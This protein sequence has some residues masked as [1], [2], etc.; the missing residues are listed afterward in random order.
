MIRDE[1]SA[2]AMA[3]ATPADRD[4]W[5]DFLRALSILV[6]VV[7]HWLVAVVVWRDG[8]IEGFNALERIDGLW[9]ITWVLQVMPIFFFVGGFSN[10]VSLRAARRRGVGYAGYLHGR[11]TRM[12]RP[13][14][15]FLGL[16]VV[17][18][19]TLDALN[20]ADDIVFPV[21]TLITG[22]LW[23][24]GVYMIVVALAP[25]MVALHERLGFR[26][27]VAL[28]ALTG[29]VDLV[30][31][32]GGVSAVGYANYP[33][34]WL[35]AHQWGFVYADG[36]LTALR[37]RLLA[38]VGFAGLVAL[39]SFG[40]Y[41]LSMVG[42]A[43][44]EFS[45]MDPPTLCIVAL[46]M[47]E[48]GLAVATRGAV[49]RWLQRPRPWTAVI[50]VN[51]VIMTV[52]LWHLTVLVVAIGLLYPVGFPQPDV[53]T[54]SWWWWRPVWV[55]T[56]TVLLAGFVAA[57]G[58]VERRGLTRSPGGGAARPGSA[59]LAVVAVTA[60]LVGVL[61][62]AVGGLHQVFSPTGEDL[63]VMAVNPFQNV[64]HIAWGM[65]ALAA[66]SGR[67]GR[68]S[69]A[70]L[71]SMAMAAAL[72]VAGP[73]LRGLG[74]GNVLALDGTGDVLHLGLAVLAAVAWVRSRSGGT[75]V[76]RESG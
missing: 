76:D 12:M 22:P 45:N 25:V 54:A 70:A 32:A 34:V 68:I 48:V 38:A 50:V 72:A 2:A 3:A 4:R 8:R 69:P 62:F 52:F 71:V 23:F 35:L 47:W 58:A 67:F 44:D 73:V 61:G 59:L 57:F 39:V 33:L 36:G 63:I 10:L 5:I 1:P 74:E 6:V 13:T 20:L 24:L 27:I 53:G 49:A 75:I 29:A 43:T 9:S 65:V 41:P 7:G 37:G 42:L 40:P 60:T 46:T 30:R 16:S 15:L 17:V 28:V 18:V 19:A 66:A 31:F 26:V 56:L 64:V 14:A 21:A 55:A 11:V 51:S